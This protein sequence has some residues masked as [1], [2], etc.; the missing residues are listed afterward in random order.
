MQMTDFSDK[1]INTHQRDFF[2]DNDRSGTEKILGRYRAPL[3]ARASQGGEVRILGVGGRPGYSASTVISF[4]QKQ[5]CASRTTVLD[6]TP[7]LSM[8]APSTHC[9][10]C[11]WH[12]VMG[13]RCAYSLSPF[14]STILS[15]IL[16]GG[17]PF[18]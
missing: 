7:Y 1:Q 4:F 17:G 10:R 11:R 16:P 3:L 13:K 12:A 6:I 9:E 15:L 2:I 14:S 18:R 5:Q 8:L